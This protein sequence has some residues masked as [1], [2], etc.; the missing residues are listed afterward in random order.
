MREI[1]DRLLEARTAIDDAIRRQRKAQATLGVVMNY[2]RLEEARGNVRKA[3]RWLAL[4]QDD[5][6]PPLASSATQETR[7]PPPGTQSP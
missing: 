7:S 2:L 6:L 4:V 1:M 3:I 5:A